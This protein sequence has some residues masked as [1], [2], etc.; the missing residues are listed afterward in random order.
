MRNKTIAISNVPLGIF[1]SKL[2]QGAIIEI[3]DYDK[4]QIE[5]HQAAQFRDSILRSVHPIKVPFLTDHHVIEKLFEK[6]TAISIDIDKQETQWLLFGGLFNNCIKG[7][8]QQIIDG[9]QSLN[10]SQT[11]WVVLPLFMINKNYVAEKNTLPRHYPYSDY[12]PELLSEKSIHGE[13]T[14]GTECLPYGV[15]TYFSLHYDSN[16][17]IIVRKDGATLREIKGREGQKYIFDFYTSFDKM[18]SNA[19]RIQ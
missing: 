1:L 11:N 10:L 12:I 2:T 5:T 17:T 15:K 9:N 19:F 4:T 6:S 13:I 7:T 3:V 18:L 8:I 16:L 14:T